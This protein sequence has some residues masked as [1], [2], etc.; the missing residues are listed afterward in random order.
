M[1]VV[2]TEAPDANRSAGPHSLDVLWAL[3]GYRVHLPPV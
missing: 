3:E 1:S 2:F